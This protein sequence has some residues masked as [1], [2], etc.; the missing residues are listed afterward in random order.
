MGRHRRA[1]RSMPRHGGSRRCLP[2]PGTPGS[3][4][5]WARRG[6]AAFGLLAALGALLWAALHWRWNVAGGA[7]AQAL[8]PLT[9]ETGAAAVIAVTTHGPFGDPERATGRW[10]PWL[11]LGAPG[12]LPAAPV[13]GRGAGAG[14]GG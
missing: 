11:R 12:A 9:I 3:T 8:I 1:G 10:L 14:R 6:P 13:G 5:L 7:A 2:P 4:P